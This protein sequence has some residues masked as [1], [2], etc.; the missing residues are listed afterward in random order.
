MD[1]I[2][3]KDMK[4]LGEAGAIV[5][6]N[7]GYARNY[8]IPKGFAREATKS[9]IKIKEWEKQQL[10]LRKNKEIREAKNVA[11]TLKKLSITLRCEVGESEKLYGSVQAGDIVEALANEGITLTKKQILL[12]E[13]I[14]T[15]G[16]YNIPIAI[17]PE[18]ESKVKIWVV[19]K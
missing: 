2:L 11:H 17:H 12:E 14:K 1:V 8:L 15:L 7:R 18:V 5:S 13:P 6:V 16:I 4:N 10:S 9:N 3:I 19:K